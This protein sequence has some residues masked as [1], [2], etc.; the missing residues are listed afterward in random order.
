MRSY[1]IFLLYHNMKMV[2]LTDLRKHDRIVK[3]INQ[4]KGSF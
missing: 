3:S 1:E 2:F 4:K